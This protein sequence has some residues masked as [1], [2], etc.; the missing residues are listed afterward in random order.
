MSESGRV[1]VTGMGVVAPNANSTEEFEQALRKGVSGLRHIFVERTVE[2]IVNTARTG[3][4]G[5]IGDGKIFIS[6][7]TETIRMSDGK[8][9][10][11]AV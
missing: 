5:N 1:V 4:E 10:P 7:A 11:E 6:P 2:T 3:A 9:G 8:H